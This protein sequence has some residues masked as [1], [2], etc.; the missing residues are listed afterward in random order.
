MRRL[1]DEYDLELA[2]GPD[3]RFAL[4]DGVAMAPYVDIFVMQVQLVQTEPA[5]VRDFVIPLA[6]ELRQANPDIRISAQVRTE[7]DVDE[8]VDLIASMRDS[9]D[10]ISILTSPETVDIAEDLVDT[11]RA[12]SSETN[13]VG[14]IPRDKSLSSEA[15]GDDRQPSE[16]Q[17]QA[18]SSAS[19]DQTDSL[20]RTRL[21]LA[22]TVGLISGGLLVAAAALALRNRARK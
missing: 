9:L 21:G 8:I 5:R 2:L 15:A 4:S 7:G 22:V 14:K 12:R 13:V 11:L 6:E 3:H 10:G 19:A 17:I 16:A 18:G 1:A 20:V